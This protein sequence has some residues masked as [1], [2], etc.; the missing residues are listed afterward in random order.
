MAAT[1]A[2][3]ATTL[4]VPD[5]TPVAAAKQPACPIVSVTT[6]TTVLAHL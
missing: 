2:H 1:I 4:A 5:P 3:M 6:R